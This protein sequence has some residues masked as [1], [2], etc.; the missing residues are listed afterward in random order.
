MSNMK[1]QMQMV[2]FQMIASVGTAKSMYI[3]S[4]KKARE[5]DFEA[6][7]DLIKEG[8]KMQVEASH[9]HLELVQKEASGMDL[10]F[11]LILMHAEDQM[12]TNESFKIMAEEI[13]FLHKKTTNC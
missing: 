13:L 9:L 4:M 7:E 8:Y 5:G 10:P 12:L 2:A 3:D 11:S 6:A 1:E